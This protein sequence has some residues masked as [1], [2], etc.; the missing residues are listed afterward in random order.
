LIDK[1]IDSAHAIARGRIWLDTEGQTEAGRVSYRTGLVH[2]LEA[3]GEAQAGAAECLDP[4]VFAEYAFLGQEL[5]FCLPSDTKTAASLSAALQG[6]DEA[7]LALKEADAGSSYGVVDR[8]FSHRREYRFAAMPKD[9]FH[10]A[11]LSH[12][13]RLDNSLRSPS[14]S[15]AEKDLLKQRY[16]NI[17]TAQSV[18]LIK[19]KKALGVVG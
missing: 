18:Y 13:A 5:Q 6:F 3:F 16:E 10:V 12:K 2:A 15:A 1:I 14:V 17:K 7:L 19:Q 11:C 8:C 9:A 4:L